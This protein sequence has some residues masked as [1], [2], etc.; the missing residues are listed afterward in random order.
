MRFNNDTYLKAFPRSEKAK[1]N[2][3]VAAGNVIEDAEAAAPAK[4]PA[5]EAP[6]NVIEDAPAGQDPEPDAQE[7]A[8][9]G[10][11]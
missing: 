3:E 7:G 6:G 4:D 2:V 11:E 1:T 10:S 9:N 5:P 8:D